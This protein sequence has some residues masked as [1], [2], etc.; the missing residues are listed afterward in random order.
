MERQILLLL[1]ANNLKIISEIEDI[2][3]NI[4]EPDCKLINPYVVDGEDL[5]PWME[6]YTNETELM[7]SSDKILTLVEP[8]EKLLEDYLKLTK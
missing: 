4:G 2:G 8:K 3:S 7:I 1:L 5:S 6:E